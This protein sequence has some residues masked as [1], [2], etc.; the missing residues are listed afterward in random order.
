MD[1]S[2]EGPDTLSVIALGFFLVAKV[3][4]TNSIHD[5]YQIV[6]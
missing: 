6:L 2:S 1:C 5:A 4:H 3:Y